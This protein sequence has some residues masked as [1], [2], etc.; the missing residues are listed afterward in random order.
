L[1]KIKKKEKAIT[2]NRTKEKLMSEDDHYT[3]LSQS[4][5]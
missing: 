1:N 4:P 2:T 3:R 5:Q